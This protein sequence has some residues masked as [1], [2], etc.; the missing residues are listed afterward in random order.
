MSDALLQIEIS[1]NRFV[2]TQ[3]D[4]NFSS[5]SN[6]ETPWRRIHDIAK[7]AVMDTISNHGT[8]V[9]VSTPEKI[10]MVQRATAEDL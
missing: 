1:L 6:I 8:F 3:E 9:L 4:G 5:R 7:T 10:T 2:K